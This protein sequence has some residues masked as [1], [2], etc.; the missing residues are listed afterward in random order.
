[1]N[2]KRVV[3]GKTKMIAHRGC[4]Y[5]EK[6]NTM[7]AFI[8]AGNRTYFGIETDVHLTADG[9]YIIIHD[10][11]TQRVG[12]DCI[13][14]EKSSFDSL[15]RITLRDIDGT[16]E[17]EDLHL[18]SLADYIKNCVK[19]EKVG[20]L[21][22]KAPFTVEQMDEVMAMIGDYK[23]HMII[24]SFHW[25]ALVN[26][27]VHHPD[28]QAQ[29][30]CGAVDDAKLDELAKYRFGLD[31]QYGAMNEDLLKKCRKRGIETNVW[32]VDS[33]EDCERLAKMGVDYI[34]SNCCEAR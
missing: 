3:V 24:I 34:T 25:D 23:D 6:E 28:Q 27:R 18:P 2:T 20:V 1:M 10:P 8:A 15:R 32:T 9:K 4:S 11:N 33:P 17:R 30:L 31:I 5:L 26:L 13:D 21:E 12:V 16:H 29:F 19:Y 7:A 14:V 22:I